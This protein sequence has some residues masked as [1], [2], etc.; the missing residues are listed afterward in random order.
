MKMMMMQAVPVRAVAATAETVPLNVTA[1]GTVQA[2]H[3]VD[4][5]SQIAGQITEV[6]F[7]PGQ[8]V[9]KGQLLFQ[10]D[11]QPV[12]AQIAQIQADINKDIALE[13]QAQANKTKDQATLKQNQSVADR[14]LAL[15]KAG[16]NSKEQTEQAV[17]TANASKASVEA[18][19]AAIKSATASLKSDRARLAAEQLQLGYTKITAPISGRA[20]AIAVRAGN[21]VSD[22][23]TTLV[24]LL[25]M[26]PIYVSF[27]LPEQL[28]PQV[29]QHN[30]RQPLLVTAAGDGEKPATGK[31]V[32]IDNT[33]DTTTG[34]VNLKAQFKN[35]DQT[36]WPGEFVNT[37]L[38]L[39]VQQNQTVVPT[40]TV[41]NGP[42]GKYV[43][44]MDSA[45]SKVS[46]R[47]VQVARNYTS[48]GQELA[49]I[50][51]GV[52]PGEM[53]ISEGQMR[54]RPGAKV[55]LLKPDTQT[56]S[57]PAAKEAS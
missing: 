16:I 17:A 45:T 5:K 43:W 11:P 22:N 1:V 28:L 41:E 23:G 6:N 12:L 49:V 40:R 4:V 21:L 14:A 31:L 30:A 50:E 51:N 52:H 57:R 2:I 35:P 55:K 36:L 44:V 19:E 7:E 18:D 39:Q 46:I 10:I 20:G 3:S 15:G 37:Q 48:K 13:Q 9:R 8:N 27:G 24:T 29:Q 47:P 42:Q 54:L 56:A 53:V 32:F 25:Q 26:S 38:Q 33:V 34:T